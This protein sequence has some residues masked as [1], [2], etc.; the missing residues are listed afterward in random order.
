MYPE[1]YG[2]IWGPFGRAERLEEMARVLATRR[3]CSCRE[4]RK[5]FKRQKPQAEEL[6]RAR[7]VRLGSGGNSSHSCMAPFL[8][9][10][11]RT[12]SH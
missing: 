7:G 1:G 5:E 8:I 10:E 3:A 12:V 6:R 9:S 2:N 11:V 4:S